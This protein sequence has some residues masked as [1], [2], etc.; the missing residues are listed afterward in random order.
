M[1]TIEIEH[2]TQ[3]C[4]EYLFIVLL[5]IYILLELQELN[6][7]MFTSPENYLFEFEKASSKLSKSQLISICR[8]YIS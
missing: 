3:N 1:S 8:T 2:R 6:E 7:V 4:Y 5:L